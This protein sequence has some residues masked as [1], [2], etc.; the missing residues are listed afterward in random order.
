MCNLVFLRGTPKDKDSE[1][2]DEPNTNNNNTPSTSSDA[3]PSTSTSKGQ[4]SRDTSREKAAK[5]NEQ[6]RVEED[7]AERKRLKKER[8]DGLVFNLRAAVP[9]KP[10]K[11]CCYCEG[12]SFFR[13]FIIL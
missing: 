3:A 6:K 9:G 11:C 12:T 1:A 10:G 13:G 5:R 8:L 4:K 7:K 2:G